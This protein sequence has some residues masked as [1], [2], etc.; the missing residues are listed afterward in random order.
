MSSFG[1]FSE[2][3]E[4]SLHSVTKSSIDY[5]LLQRKTHELSESIQMKDFEYQEFGLDKEEAK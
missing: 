4:T 5:L 1:D 3:F 2:N